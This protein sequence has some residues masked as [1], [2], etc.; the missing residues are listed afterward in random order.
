MPIVVPAV[1]GFLGDRL[2]NGSPYAMGPL[3]VC[4]SCLSVTKLCMQVGLGPG[5]IVLDGDPAPLPKGAEPPNFRPISRCLLQLGYLV[6]LCSIMSDR[7]LTFSISFTG[8]AVCQY[9]C[10]KR[11]RSYFPHRLRNF[12][13][14][15]VSLLTLQLCQLA[16]FTC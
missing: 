2:L 5:H 11:G 8:S 4:L 1:F 10:S 3:S 15:F 14:F 16:A 9:H 12:G 13:N 6:F 7:I